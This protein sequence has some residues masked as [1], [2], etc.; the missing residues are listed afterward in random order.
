MNKKLLI[1]FA[2]VTTFF[3]SAQQKNTL[4]EQSFWKTNPDVTTVQAEIAKGN[5]PSESNDRAFDAVTLAINN[6]APNTT[7]K[8][9][10]EQAGNPVTKNTHDNRRYL[11]WAASKGNIEI[12]NYLISKGA[13]IN[14]EDSLGTTAL[15]LAASSGQKNTA[16]YEAFFKAGLD[17]KK[18]YK[19]NVTLLLMAI[20]YDKDL[21]LTNYFISKGLSLKDTDKDGNTPF[22][23]A[24]KTGDLNFL[25]TL[26]E[27]GV[28]YNDNALIIAA[29]GNRRESNPIEVYQY[30]VEILKLKPT[31][32]STDEET[33]LHFLVTKPK[34][35]EI[36]NYFI[37]KGVDVNKVDKQ[38][39][40]V[41]MKAASARE[42]TEALELLLPI[43]KNS[44][45]LNTK[46]E[47]ALTIAVQSGT[48]KAVEILLNNGADV[49]IV[50]KEGYN[51]G[52]NLIQSYR[53]QMN[54]GPESGNGPKQ[55]PFATKMK[56]LQDKGL[57]LAAPQ[58]DG[59]TL[60]H[61]ALL[62]ND[63]TLLK[64]LADLKIDVNAKNKEGLTA[65]HKAAM[66]A[67]DDVI[68]KYLISI[69]AKND[70]KTEFDETAYALAKENETL[71]QNN[72]SVEFLK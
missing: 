17:P 2:L 51:L 66:V 57:D 49:K 45:A 18:K 46:G 47:S 55:D 9:L 28:K 50:N 1:S 59:S 65:L 14:Y 53:P 72:V 32:V 10:L 11:H 64:K 20:P 23:Y 13:D 61:F 6:D 21:S 69:G 68:L 41:L 16:V 7:I 58:K 25:K 63:L 5:N 71:T 40:T 29:Q 19:D 3:V 39:N 56:L 54:R 38:G 48:P 60:Y 24:T 27:K 37:A 62:K 26:V 15:V 12:V 8:F 43:V 42:N 34:Q 22:N 52:V 33:I 31:V 4:L 70:I 35:S 36:I 30:L 67:K 44:A